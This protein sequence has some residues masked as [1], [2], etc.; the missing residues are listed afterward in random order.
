MDAKLICQTPGVAL[1]NHYKGYFPFSKKNN[2]LQ[3]LYLMY[4]ILIYYLHLLLFDIQ[5]KEVSL[6]CVKFV[7]GGSN[8]HS[9]YK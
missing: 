2:N 4:K 8:K 5:T 1:N 3:I 6:F 9:T 7:V